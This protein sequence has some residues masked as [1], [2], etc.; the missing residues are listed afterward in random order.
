MKICLVGPGIMPIPPNGWGAVESIIWDCATELGELDYDGVILNT[1]NEDDILS[2]IEE[3]KF[4][5]IHIHYDV[6]CN[7]IPDIKRVSPKSIIA[8]SS[9]YPYIDQYDKHRLDGYNK[10]FDW[11]ISNSILFYNFCVSDKDLNV[12]KLKGVD[13]NKLHLF[14]TGAQH[15]DI[16]QNLNP[17]FND[18]SIC[19]GKIDKRKMQFLYQSID[20]IDF[21]G[22]IGDLYQFNTKK[23]YMGEWTRKEIYDKVGEYSNIILLSMG[24][25]GTPLVIKEALMSGLGVVT[26][27]YCAYEL[28]TT[29][30]FIS[31]IPTDKLKDLDYVNKCLI[32]NREVSISMRKEIIEYAIE[33]FS[34][35][36]IIKSY[37]ETII[38]LV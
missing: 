26:S 35:E 8:L 14:K 1:P 38:K 32:E 34:W 37:I 36:R 22:P 19:I 17:K 24:E 30:P 33:N 6:F 13:E 4:D 7:L 31:I 9:H 20:T 12:F 18:R 3:E 11:M 25:N 15:R 21:V 10:I 27:E 2:T 16:K 5:F 29:L 23:N 28:D